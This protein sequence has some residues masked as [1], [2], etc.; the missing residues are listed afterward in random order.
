MSKRLILEDQREWKNSR[1]KL[2]RLHGKKMGVREK[3][4]YR[5]ENFSIDPETGYWECG[6]M[7]YVCE[8]CSA[9]HF[10]SERNR[11]TGSTLSSLKFSECC[12]N[13]QVTLHFYLVCRVCVVLRILALVKVNYVRLRWM[14]P[15]VRAEIHDSNSRCLRE[16]KC[17]KRFPKPLGVEVSSTEGNY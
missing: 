5:R 2:R 14:K 8:F 16:W 6:S 3:R 7:T 9:L 13:G 4:M 12:S 11:R 17:T 1:K 10:L 15:A